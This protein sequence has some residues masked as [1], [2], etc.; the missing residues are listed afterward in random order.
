MCKRG[1]QSQQLQHVQNEL[2]HSCATHVLIHSL[3]SVGKLY[4]TRFDTQLSKANDIPL[5]V[6]FVLI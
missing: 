3:C 6:A 4:K 2:V 1:L 5:T